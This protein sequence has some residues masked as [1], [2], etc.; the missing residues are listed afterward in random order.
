MKSTIIAALALF[1]NQVEAAP[2]QRTTPGWQLGTHGAEVEIR[3]FLDLLCPD[4]RDAY[5]VFKQLLPKDSPVAGKTYSDLIDL[6][7]TAFVLPYHL[8]SYK[9][10]QVVPYL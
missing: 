9:M 8:H 7:V 1:S 6:K 5:A 10:T 3:V 2:I 4:S